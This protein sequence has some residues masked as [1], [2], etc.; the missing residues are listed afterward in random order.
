MSD[1][2]YAEVRLRRN[3]D[4][5]NE[6]LVAKVKFEDAVLAVRAV[7]VLTVESKVIY[8]IVHARYRELFKEV[9][10]AVVLKELAQEE[11]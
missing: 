4:R 9:A 3:V 2:C 6:A 8:S 11:V 10:L 1:V 5:A 7:E